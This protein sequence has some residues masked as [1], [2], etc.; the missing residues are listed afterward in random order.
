MTSTTSLRKSLD[1]S[2]VIEVRLAVHRKQNGATRRLVAM[3]R[4]GL[5]P[6]VISGRRHSVVIL[7]AA[8]EDKRLLNLRVLMKGD[9]RT[10]SELQ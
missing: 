4:T 7:D 3:Q 5:A 9:A 1:Q 10:A 8:L 2:V 6:G